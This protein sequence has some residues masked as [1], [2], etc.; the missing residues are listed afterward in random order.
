MSSFIFFFIDSE[1]YKTFAL[2]KQ[3]IT[4]VFYKRTFKIIFND[5]GFENELRNWKTAFFILV[6]NRNVD[7]LRGSIVFSLFS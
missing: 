3:N 4:S 2:V 6:I 7:T 1:K 5:S